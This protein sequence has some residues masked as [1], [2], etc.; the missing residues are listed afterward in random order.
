MGEDSVAESESSSEISDQDSVL[1]H[2]AHDGGVDG[3]LLSD[4]LGGEGLL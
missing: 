1:L 3:L 4:E 2:L